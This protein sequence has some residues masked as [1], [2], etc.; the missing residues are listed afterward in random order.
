MFYRFIFLLFPLVFWAQNYQDL[1]NE[2]VLLNMK[3]QN[4]SSTQEILKVSQK[5]ERIYQEII[6]SIA[7]QK[8]Q[9]SSN[10]QNA[11]ENLQLSLNASTL[12][13]ELL[14][15]NTLKLNSLLSQKAMQDLAISIYTKNSFFT[16]KSQI[17]N[18]I[19]KTLKHLKSYTLIP[20]KGLD[21]IQKQKLQEQM[22]VFE[23][24]TES[25]IEILNFLAHNVKSLT[26]QSIWS[27]INLPSL[28]E[29]IEKILPD[30]ISSPILAKSIV[31]LSV[32]ITLFFFR[33]IIA[34]LIIRVLSYFSK[35]LKNK[36]VQ[37]KI[38]NDI[39]KPIL[40]FLIISSFSISLGVLTFPKP[41]SPN[42]AMWVNASYIITL[43]WFTILLF[44]GYGIAILGSIAEKNNTFRR[45][46]I[47]LLLKIIYFL[48][49]LV[50][51]L[52]LLKNF[53]F[54]ISALIAS[55]G[56]GGLAVAFAVKDMLANFFASV[57][58]LFDNSFNQ[59]D[60]I[61][62]GDIEGTVVEMGLRRTTIRTFDNAMLFVPNSLLANSSVRNWNRRKRGRRIRMQIGITYDSTP[63]QIRSCIKDI[64]TMLINHPMIAKDND[65][66]PPLSHYELDLKQ[67]IV[68]LDDLLG[69]KSNLFV[70]L[71]EFADSSINILV[72]CF[73]TTVVWGEW[74]DV[75]QDV[76]LKIMDILATHNLSFAFPSQSLY[77][78]E[79]PK[80]S[81]AQS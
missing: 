73:S 50:A 18:L 7:T 13:P 62:C 76:M 24:T 41:V 79:I 81:L 42:F 66:R 36:E 6:S 5:K 32:F 78:E 53:G 22:T 68:S 21:Q 11:I 2:I 55:L 27:N 1:L 16:T 31:S 10:L 70:V 72:Y 23:I 40:Y 4:L 77:I 12:S 38:K 33:H 67:N 52:I 57:V 71:D 35:F 39:S 25:Y 75:R 17:Q 29:W 74:L 56:I 48:I 80:V 58:L 63:E 26:P 54:N 28:L 47:N 20:T 14:A 9:D 59:G 8:P 69:Y 45:E 64:K 51:I 46:V 60:W 44:K 30:N 49:I 65:E 19:E 43:S 34:H 37:D 61:V 3:N 15:Y